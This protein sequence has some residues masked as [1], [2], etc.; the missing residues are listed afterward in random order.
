MIRKKY[1][2]EFKEQII[3][4][5]QETGNIALVARRYEISPNTIHTWL[6]K[7]R[8]RGSVKTLPR[9]ETARTKAMEQRLKE[10]S[11]QNDQLKRLLAEKELELAI[12][13]EV[14][15]LKNPH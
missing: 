14:R 10:V 7:Y 9:V 13:R 1:S 4:E 5:C 2:D 6:R 11:L 12:L 3:R 8:Q 15:Y